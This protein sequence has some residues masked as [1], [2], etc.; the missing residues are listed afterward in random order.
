MYE[1]LGSIPSTK[2]MQKKEKELLTV[3]ELFYMD[4]KTYDYMHLLKSTEVYTME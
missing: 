4:W 3:V 2:K 1:T